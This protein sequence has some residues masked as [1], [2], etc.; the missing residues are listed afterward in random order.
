MASL[1]SGIAQRPE[2]DEQQRQQQQ[3]VL[4]GGGA[5]APSTSGTS[6]APKPNAGA[7]GMG[8]QQGPQRSAMQPRGSG[9]VNLQSFLTPTVAKQNQGAVRGMGADLTGRVSGAFDTANAADRTAIASNAPKTTNYWDVEGLAK[10]AGGGDQGATAQLRGLLTQ[11]FDG[12]LKSTFDAAG[13]ADYQRMAKL[14]G[15]GTALDALHPG[16]KGENGL[17]RPSVTQGNSW[18]DQALIQGD[19]GTLGEIKKVDEGGSAL[20]KFMAGEQAKTAQLATDTKAGVDKARD[21]A[22]G[23]AKQYIDVTKAQAEQNARSANAA[24]DALMANAAAGTNGITNVSP[25]ERATA[26][27]FLDK[28]T[29]GG[30]NALAGM[31]GDPSFGAQSKDPYKAPTFSQTVEPNAAPTYAESP[32]D[33]SDNYKR[34]P[35]SGHWTNTATGETF[36]GT[37]Q[38]NPQSNTWKNVISGETKSAGQA[39]GGAISADEYRSKM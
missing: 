17:L 39:V 10:R 22:Q 28:S 9:F 24:T 8:I 21:D 6:A 14:S 2:D 25:G 26:G 20:A 31:L 29:A 11:S 13:N 37:W 1:P 18:L 15:A 38:Y 35:S 32:L 5:P 34:D 33:Y 12:P 36:D 23:I 30:L 27:N 3:P 19:A 16:R 7:P 4:S